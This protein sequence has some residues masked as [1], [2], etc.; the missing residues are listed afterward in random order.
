MEEN[1]KVTLTL[2]DEKLGMD[3]AGNITGPDLLAALFTAVLSTARAMLASVPEEH[4]EDATEEIY[5]MINAGASNVLELFAPEIEM[6]PDL[7]VEALLDAENKILDTA[8]EV[9]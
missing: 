9:D 3:V 2:E 1:I 5:D 6:R 4:Q 8:A 7:T